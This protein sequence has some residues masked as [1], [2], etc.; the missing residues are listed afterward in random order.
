MI[1]LRSLYF[2]FRNIYWQKEGKGAFTFRGLMIDAPLVLQVDFVLIRH[3]IYYL[4]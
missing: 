1:L 2:Q 4:K 3:Y